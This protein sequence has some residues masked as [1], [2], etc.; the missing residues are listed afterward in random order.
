MDGTSGLMEILLFDREGK[1][2]KESTW[3][4]RQGQWKYFFERFLACQHPLTPSLN[5]A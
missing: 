4:A 5:Y 2:C 3:D 1:S